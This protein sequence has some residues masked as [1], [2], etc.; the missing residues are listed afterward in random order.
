MSLIFDRHPGEW[1]GNKSISMVFNHLFKVYK[2]IRNFE[3]C[4]FGDENIYFD[5]IEKTATTP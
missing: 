3:I 2:P 4:L 5:K 1:H